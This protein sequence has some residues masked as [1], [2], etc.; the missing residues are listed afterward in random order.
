MMIDPITISQA[1]RQNFE[2]RWGPE[3]V[4]RCCRDWLS[5]YM[6]EMAWGKCGLCGRKPELVV[7]NWDDYVTG[8]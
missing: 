5:H 2:V 8:S 7:K 3:C 4:L 6:T 1:T